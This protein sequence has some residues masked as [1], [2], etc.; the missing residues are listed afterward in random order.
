[1]PAHSNYEP[2]ERMSDV[3]CGSRLCLAVL[4]C[5]EKGGVSWTAQLGVTES[6][7]DCGILDTISVLSVFV[8][9]IVYD[10]ACSVV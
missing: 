7:G 3:A 2:S 9:V 6:V 5:G 8:L 1:M 10:T 4:N